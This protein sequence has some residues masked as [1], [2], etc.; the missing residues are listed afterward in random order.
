MLGCQHKGYRLRIRWTVKGKI[1]KR[2]TR[3]VESTEAV[4]SSG[5]TRSNCET[6]VGRRDWSE[7]VSSIVEIFGQAKLNNY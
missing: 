1:H 5:L 3:K 4:F 6:L 7:G 2:K